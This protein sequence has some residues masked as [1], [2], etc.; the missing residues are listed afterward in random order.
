MNHQPDLLAGVPPLRFMGDVAPEDVPRLTR[1]LLRFIAYVAD[2]EEH[3][4]T[5]IA[6]T[7]GM[8]ACSASARYRDIKR[9][10]Y[11]Y[12]KRRDEKIAGLWHYKVVEIPDGLES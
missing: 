4:L 9:L 11:R 1:H 8:S 10:G 6:T 7:L 3:T 12:T 5:E 2:R